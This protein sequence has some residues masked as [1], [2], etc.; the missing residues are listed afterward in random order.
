MDANFFRLG[1]FLFYFP[2]SPFCTTVKFKLCH[3]AEQI[4]NFLF[5]GYTFSE[6][7]LAPDGSEGAFEIQWSSVSELCVTGPFL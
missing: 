7:F 5:F 3:D 1:K 4:Q 6:V 2:P